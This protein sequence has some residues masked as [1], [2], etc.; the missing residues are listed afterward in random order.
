MRNDNVQ[1]TPLGEWV[2][3]GI[4]AVLCVAMGWAIL[5]AFAV[6]V[7]RIGQGLGVI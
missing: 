6:I 4:V 7:V 1:L 2:Y 5:K 3:S